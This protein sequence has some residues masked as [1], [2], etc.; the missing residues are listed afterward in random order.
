[1]ATKPTYLTGNKAAINEFVDKFDVR[2]YASASH[3]MISPIN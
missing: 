2:D 3:V 1:M